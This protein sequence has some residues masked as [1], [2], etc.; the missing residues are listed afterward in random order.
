MCYNA[1]YVYE[2]GKSVHIFTCIYVLIIFRYIYKT[3]VT[4]IA[5]E[6]RIWRTEMEKELA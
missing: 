3:I 2:K 1:I 5:V 4:L 6:K